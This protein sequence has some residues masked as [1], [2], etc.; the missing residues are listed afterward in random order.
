MKR[1]EA[2]GA[3]CIREQTKVKDILL[4]SR[5][6]KW[7]WAG[8][9]LSGTETNIWISRVTDWYRQRLRIFC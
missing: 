7:A 6:K 9:R 2:K 5:N 4:A 8:H 1:Q 3:S